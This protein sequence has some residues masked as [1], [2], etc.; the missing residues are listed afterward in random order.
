[1][2]SDILDSKADDVAAAKLAVYGKIEQRQIPE[3]C[4]NLGDGSDQAA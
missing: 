4:R 3:L 1:M 2:W